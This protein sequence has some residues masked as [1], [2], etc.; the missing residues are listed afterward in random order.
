MSDNA[1][2]LAVTSRCPASGPLQAQEVRASVTAL[3]D[4]PSAT[5]V[6]NGFGLIGRNSLRCWLGSKDKLT[7]V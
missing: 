2:A 3:A 6:I 1:E 5:V 7:I 4:G